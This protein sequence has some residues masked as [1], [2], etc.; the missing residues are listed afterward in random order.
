MLFID[1]GGGGVWVI[2]PVLE[3]LGYKPKFESVE[4]GDSVFTGG[5]F[6]KFKAGASIPIPL[7]VPDTSMFGF[8]A[9]PMSIMEG[10]VG[11]LGHTWFAGRVWVFDYPKHQ[12]SVYEATPPAR[13]FGPH[14]I[15]MTLKKPLSRNDPR[16]QVDVAG[17]T[18]DMLLDT[19]ATSELTPE[20]LAVMGPGPS[21][22]ASAFVATRCGIGGGRRIRNGGSCRARK[23]TGPRR[24]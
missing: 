4:E 11:M 1:S 23:R 2:K 9:A 19:G 5:K 20:A 7:G 24:T 15:P 8:G 12:L 17:D 6:P 16:I 21:T 3:R 10:A 22:R 13:P 14:T 18:I